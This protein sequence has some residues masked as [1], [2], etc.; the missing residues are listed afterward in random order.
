[1]VRRG[2]QLA[3]AGEGY[4]ETQTRSARP[5]SAITHEPIEAAGPARAFGA[6]RGAD[7]AA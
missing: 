4:E 7:D 5:L 6:A 3:Q 2:P 1:M